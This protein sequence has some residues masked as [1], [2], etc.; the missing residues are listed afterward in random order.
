M[1]PNPFKLLRR[2]GFSLP[3]ILV[4][5]AVIGVL[6]AIAIPVYSNVTESAKNVQADDFAETLNKSVR[7]YGQA[8]WEMPTAGD[9]AATTDEFTVIRSLQYKWPATSMKPG[10]P[11]FSQLYN[12]T[13]SSSSTVYR[14]RWNGRT[15]EILRPGTTGSGL[16]VPFDRSDYGTTVYAFPNNY[17]PAGAP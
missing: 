5:V 4:V 17:K 6:T 14:L 15:F 1:S 10:S 13:A 9:N 12:P 8:A 3:E 11:F 16:L 2:R 7:N